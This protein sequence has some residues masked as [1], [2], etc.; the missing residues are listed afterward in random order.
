M[1]DGK[2]ADN[3]VNENDEMTDGKDSD[4]NV[5]EN[6]EVNDGQETEND[7]D[8]NK[9]GRNKSHL[10]HTANH[11]FVLCH[12]MP[13]IREKIRIY[14]FRVIEKNGKKGII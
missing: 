7:D 6:D 9:D 4:N 14:I 2:D 12:F 8:H 3:N 5:N 11:F 1:T 13:S 10:W